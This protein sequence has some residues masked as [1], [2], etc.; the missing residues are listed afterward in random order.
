[1]RWFV[2]VLFTL[3]LMAQEAPNGLL[4]AGMMLEGLA[5]DTGTWPPGEGWDDGL[6]IEQVLGALTNP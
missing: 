4:E 1:M 2:L 6:L 5:G 3:P